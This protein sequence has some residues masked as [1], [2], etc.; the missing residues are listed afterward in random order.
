MTEEKQE[1]EREIE[2]LKKNLDAYL[3][4]FPILGVTEKEKERVIDQH[5]DDILK[6]RKKLEKE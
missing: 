4:I 3:K 2:K 6:R 1:L 5:L